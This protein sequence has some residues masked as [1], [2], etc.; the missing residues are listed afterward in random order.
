MTVIK[1]N[2]L[3]SRSTVNPLMGFVSGSQAGAILPSMQS[4]RPPWVLA[5]FF[6]YAEYWISQQ[7]P[8]PPLPHQT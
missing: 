5:G 3:R 1:P 6:S 7:Q 4:T 8:K 2:S